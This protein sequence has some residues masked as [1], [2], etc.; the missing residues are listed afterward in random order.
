LHLTEYANARGRPEL[1][2][3]WD[4][5]RNMPLVPEAVTTGSERKVWWRCRKGHHWQA[6]VA[7]RVALRR[8]CPYCSGQKVIPGETDLAT[9][10]PEVAARWH[11]IRNGRLRPDQILPHTHKRYWWQ[12]ERGHE[13]QVSP[14]VL[15]QGSG[16]PYCAGK[17]TIPGETDLATLYP[18]IAAQWHTA[19]NEGLSPG[20][21]GPGNMKKVWWLCERGHDYQSPVFSRTQGAGC[22][23]CAGKRAWPG[24]NDVE[25]LFPRLAEE[26][27]PT[28]NAALTPRDVTRG[29]HKVIWWK[30]REGHVW[31]AAVFSRAKRNGTGCPVCAGTIRR[32]KVN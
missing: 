30:C 25:T 22:P 13:W 24:F 3:Q 19:K 29:S 2:S 32:K 31:K 17:R 14:T 27:H 23:Y 26:W 10:H 4:S 20:E 7:S 1:L 12:C 11:P 8:G 6:S 5:G 18:E 9:K 28:M 15:V 16:C 21:L